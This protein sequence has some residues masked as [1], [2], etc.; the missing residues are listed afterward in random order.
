MQDEIIFIANDDHANANAML[1]CF[2]LQKK[3]KIMIS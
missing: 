1:L 3:K 2:I